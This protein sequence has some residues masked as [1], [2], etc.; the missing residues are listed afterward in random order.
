MSLLDTPL[1]TSLSTQSTTLR[2]DLK[3]FERD[4]FAKHSRRPGRDD[5]KQDGTIAAKY[6]DYNKVRDVLSGKIPA[7]SL[8]DPSSPTQRRKQSSATNHN[9]SPSQTR[10]V[11]T[12]R[13]VNGQLRPHH[14]D[15]YD[16]PSSASPRPQITAV[17]PTPQR[18]G[19]VMGLFDMLETDGGRTRSSQKRKF[20]TFVGDNNEFTTN[21]V[22]TAS[23]ETVAAQT[24]ARR[25]YGNGVGDILDHL[26]SASRTGNR[27]KHS[28]TPPSEGRKFA[29][30]Q[31]FATPSAIRYVSMINDP[32]GDELQDGQAMLIGT[33]TSKAKGT[34]L[35]DR[36]LS[37]TPLKAIGGDEQHEGDC[38]PAYLK[39]SHSFKQRLLSASTTSSAVQTDSRNNAGGRSQTGVPRHLVKSKYNP[40]SLSQIAQQLKEREAEE[41]NK[42]A[43]AAAEAAGDDDELDALREMEGGDD[44]LV[45]NSQ[46]AGLDDGEDLDENEPQPPV[47]KWKKRGQK[48]TT[49]RSI[50]RPSK[51]GVY[52][53]NYRDQTPP[54]AAE[55]DE[56]ENEIDE[57]E[58]DNSAANM[59]ADAQTETQDVV[60]ETQLHPSSH[61]VTAEFEDHFSDDELLAEIFA[62]SDDE[63]FGIRAVSKSPAPNKKMRKVE[64]V[65]RTDDDDDD[66]FLEQ[67]AEGPQEDSPPRKKTKSSST[68]PSKSTA[69]SNSKANSKTAKPSK[70]KKPKPT[71]HSDSEEDAPTRKINPNAQSHMNFRSLKIKGKGGHA[72]RAGGGRFRGKRR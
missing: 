29:L 3:E 67:V 49:R 39:R 41:A 27:N 5:I 21:G 61:T 45:G 62:N 63:L 64:P 71:A 37:R 70:S 28:R 25:K 18:D 48:R 56:D 57:P 31:F 9:I 24:P 35:L 69:M 68:K 53:P 54:A 47:R 19:M 26:G 8:N 1:R 40:R 52:D 30:S 2:A 4:F 17:G 10:N 43:E 23:Q 44:V 50:M 36:V 38:T 34:P 22:S 46:F 12:P 6:K 7:E 59:E 11:R 15:P 65:A 55:E 13:K 32:T 33:P 58:A 60:E 16:A 20:T 42:R 14:L 66:D 72:K 51:V